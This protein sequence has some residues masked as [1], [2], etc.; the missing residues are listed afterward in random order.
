MLNALIALQCSGHVN[1]QMRVAVLQESLYALPE[2]ADIMATWNSH[3]WFCNPLL[4][5]LALGRQKTSGAFQIPFLTSAITMHTVVLE[6][7][8]SASFGGSNNKSI[9]ARDLNDMQASNSF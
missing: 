9:N 5:C 3:S 6:I 4:W 7:T 2:K 8:A 1:A